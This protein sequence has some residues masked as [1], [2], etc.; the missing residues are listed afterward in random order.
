MTEHVIPQ[1]E[2][3]PQPIQSLGF[4]YEKISP[5]GEWLD[6][7]I[8]AVYRTENKTTYLVPVTTGE[9]ARWTEQISALKHNGTPCHLLPA[10]ADSYTETER[11]FAQT[12]LEQ[13]STEIKTPFAVRVHTEEAL[14]FDPN[15]TKSVLDVM[16][17]T[18]QD[19]SEIRQARL[20]ALRGEKNEIVDTL[21]QIL[22]LNTLLQTDEKQAAALRTAYGLMH[23]PIWLSD[24]IG[25]LTEKGTQAFQ[26]RRIKQR[27]EEGIDPEVVKASVTNPED[28]R[29][30]AQAGWDELIAF[31]RTH[32]RDLAQDGIYTEVHKVGE[33]VIAIPAIASTNYHGDLGYVEFGGGHTL[34]EMYGNTELNHRDLPQE[35]NAVIDSSPLLR[36]SQ[37]LGII[38]GG[39]TTLQ[40]RCRT[41][42]TADG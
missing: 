31:A 42:F 38:S 6:Q 33:V 2:S 27:I 12:T 8:V 24:T 3:T 17:A 9:D 23:Q 14:V 37:Q 18:G 1:A 21:G 26:F 30:L 16:I 40:R 41:T 32:N 10:G 13:P 20:A 7:A 36:L 39:A 11:A 5:S 28:L 29:K 19:T 34:A 22:E 15:S 35:L 4:G 25:E